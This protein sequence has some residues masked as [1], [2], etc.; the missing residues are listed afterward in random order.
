MPRYALIDPA[1]PYPRPVLGW[2]DTDAFD[3]P[4]LPDAASLVTV[5]EAVWSHR[6][7]AVQHLTAVGFRDVAQPAFPA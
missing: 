5:P 1:T 7:H 2:F 6:L 4:K 3:Y